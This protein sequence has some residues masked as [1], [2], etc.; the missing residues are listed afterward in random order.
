MVHDK[1]HR[2]ESWATTEAGSEVKAQSPVKTQSPVKDLEGKG[3]AIDADED[4]EGFPDQDGNSNRYWEGDSDDDSENFDEDEGTKAPG[5]TA[6]QPGKSWRVTTTGLQAYT[7][8]RGSVTEVGHPLGVWMGEL[9]QDYLKA[10]SVGTAEQKRLY[11]FATEIG[12]AQIERPLVIKD[13]RI[14]A[15]SI[16]R[17]KYDHL[18]HPMDTF[19][20]AYEEQPAGRP[21]GFNFAEEFD[22]SDDEGDP[23][24]GRISPCTFRHLAQGCQRWDNQ[25]GGLRVEIPA[26]VGSSAPSPSRLSY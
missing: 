1:E 7:M 9:A 20:V 23:E 8:M 12:E 2:P 17:P 18:S 11:D 4:K 19:P 24:A 10:G 26:D 14:E 6:D 22:I 25:E 5:C 3:K 21:P 16:P 13:D 15:V